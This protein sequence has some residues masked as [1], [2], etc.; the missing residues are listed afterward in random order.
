MTDANPA[1]FKTAGSGA[2]ARC[3]VP[4][5]LLGSGAVVDVAEAL[6]I[7]SAPPSSMGAR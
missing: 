1:V 7:E 6:S 5:R 3:P 2:V 4:E